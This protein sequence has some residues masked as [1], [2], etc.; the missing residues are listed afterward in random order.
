MALPDGVYVDSLNGVAGTAWPIGTPT[1]PVSNLTDAL[2]I[3]EARK[4]SKIYLSDPDGTGFTLPSNLYQKYEF[5][6]T[7]S[8]NLS[9]GLDFNGKKP[10]Y[11][12]FRNLAL[13][14][15][16]VHD[17]IEAYNC[18]LAASLVANGVFHDCFFDSIMTL[19]DAGIF[20][21]CSGDSQTQ[22]NI[23]NAYCSIHEYNGELILKNIS[24]SNCFVYGAS[25]GL[26]IDASCTGGIINLYGDISPLTDNH[27]GTCVVN[28]HR[29]NQKD[30]RFFQETVAPTDVDGTT[31]KDLLVR[32]TIKKPVRICGFKVTKG[33]EW[34]GFVQVRI[35]D[36]AGTTKIFPF[37]TEYVEGT[38]FTS[39][40]QAVFNFPVEVSASKGYKFQFRSDNAGDGAGKTLALTNLDVQELS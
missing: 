38:D 19:N 4:L 13:G 22:L 34:A 5:V 9:A 2:L 12:I 1:M 17:S 25:L 20:I 28:D 7:I 37:Q 10:G 36:G 32:S 21:H 6:G 3:A 26:T 8:V 29:T 33:G 35:V 40:M 24:S 14:G 16:A 18:L 15:T 39:G 31:W 30:T 11:S 23:N 27:T